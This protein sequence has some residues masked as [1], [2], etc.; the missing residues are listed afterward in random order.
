MDLMAPPPLR[1][2]LTRRGFYPHLNLQ[3]VLD[4]H[5]LLLH[6]HVTSDVLLVLLLLLN[7]DYCLEND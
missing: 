4:V 3:E 2:Y 1:S 7:L 5:L 6:L